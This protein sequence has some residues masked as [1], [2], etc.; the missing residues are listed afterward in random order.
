MRVT[1]DADAHVRVADV[2]DAQ[3]LRFFVNGVRVLSRPA[4]ADVRLPLDDLLPPATSAAAVRPGPRGPAT[5]CSATR[6]AGRR[7]G[8]SAAPRTPTGPC[9][10]RSPWSVRRCPAQARARL[11][12]CPPP[13]RGRSQ[14]HRA[15]G[16]EHPPRRGC[17]GRGRPGVDV[18]RWN[19][20]LSVV[21]AGGLLMLRFDVDP[22][23]TSDV[24]A[25]VHWCLPAPNGPPPSKQPRWTLLRAM[26]PGR[27]LRASARPRSCATPVPWGRG[28]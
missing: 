24:L 26:G 21:P 1:V 11:V 2:D 4:G 3:E 5:S 15:A 25:T 10:P 20:P 6:W 9:G 17:T 14:R 13:R 27:T 23:C 8:R 7:L 12:P 28:V 19:F 22:G 16:R 18:N